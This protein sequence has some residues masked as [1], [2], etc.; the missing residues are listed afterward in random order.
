MRR[1]LEVSIFTDKEPSVKH[2]WVELSDINKEVKSDWLKCILYSYKFPSVP[3]GFDDTNRAQICDVFDETISPLSQRL[4]KSHAFILT[5][6]DSKLLTAMGSEGVIKQFN[7]AG[8]GKGV[9]FEISFAGINAVSICQRIVQTVVVRGYE[10]TLDFFS[11]WTCICT[12]VLVQGQIVGLLD[13]S[14]HKMEDVRFA[15]PLVFQTARDISVTMTRNA[16]SRNLENIYLKFAQFNLTSREKEIAYAWLENH[17]VQQISDAYSL[18]EHTVRTV[19]KN[20]YAKVAVHN[21]LD[22]IYKFNDI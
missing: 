13:L 18:S 8:I 20:I 7:K 10:H 1:G 15:V 3:Q 2:S 4:T 6:P 11:E 14:F 22:F 16:G 12:P 17:T 21:R 5:T 19:I 9:S